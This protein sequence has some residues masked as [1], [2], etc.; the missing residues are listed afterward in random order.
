M[1]PLKIL[2]LGLG[3]QST[4]IYYMSSM[5]ILPRLDY[6][7][8]ADPGREKAKT[9]QYLNYLLNWQKENNG[10][11]IIVK[12][13]KNLYTDL[14]NKQNSTGNRF[15]SIPAFTAS[16]ETTGMLNRQCTG[17]YKIAVVDNAIRELYGLPKKARRPAT[18]VYKG[19]TSDEMERMSMPREAWKILVYPFCGYKTTTTTATRVLNFDELRMNRQ[20]VISWYIENALPI[21]P[22]S[23][24]VFCPYQSEQAWADMKL[25]DPED[26]E[27]ACLVDD[28][29]RDSS[30]QGV[31]APVYLHE[32]LQPLRSVKFDLTQPDLFKGE[33][34]GEECVFHDKKAVQL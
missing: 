25:N 21:P 13:D 6:A 27:A 14:L 23:S 8:F 5:G 19:I 4:A 32:S 11:P 20:M 34:T 29:I 33:C 10:V 17:E 9:Y 2:S 1:Q 18:E 26:F 12:A 28:A 24:C 15:S 7:I 30:K 16:G 22:K 31:N 3:V